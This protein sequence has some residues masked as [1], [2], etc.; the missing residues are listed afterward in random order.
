MATLEEQKYACINRMM[1]FESMPEDLQELSRKYG[2]QV[3]QMYAKG[4]TKQEII[5]H[6]ALRYGQ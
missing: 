1:L 2:G 3:D 6:L 4:K 5:N